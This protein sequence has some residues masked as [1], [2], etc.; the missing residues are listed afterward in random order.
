MKKNTR[1]QKYLF[2]LPCAA[3]TQTIY[4]ALTTLAI[5]VTILKSSEQLKSALVIKNVY[6][7][8]TNIGG[9]TQEKMSLGNTITVD[10]LWQKYQS[11]VKIIANKIIHMQETLT[12]KRCTVKA[13]TTT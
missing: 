12:G 11:L 8:T 10:T 5:P 4:D 3:H 13:N 2:P 6:I 7:L 1:T 9:L